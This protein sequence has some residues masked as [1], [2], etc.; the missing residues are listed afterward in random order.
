MAGEPLSPPEHLT[1]DNHSIF[2]NDCFFEPYV[3]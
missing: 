3:T 1:P 2:C